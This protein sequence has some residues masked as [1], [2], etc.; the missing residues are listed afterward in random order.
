[1]TLHKSNF[2][3]EAN[4]SVFVSDIKLSELNMPKI[5]VE[6]QI[7]ENF[8]LNKNLSENDIK[9]LTPTEEDFL[10]VSEYLIKNLNLA[11]RIDVIYKRINEKVS[12]AKI[13]VILSAMKE[14]GIL[15]AVWKA[16]KFKIISFDPD[17]EIKFSDLKILKALAAH[18]A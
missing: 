1:V 3:N 11:Q 14:C 7:Y 6:K 16:D 9:L 15:N 18:C 2:Q 8:K 4:F 10:T 5:L 17:K 13:Y 12:P